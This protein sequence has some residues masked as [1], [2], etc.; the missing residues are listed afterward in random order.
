M[1]STDPYQNL[2]QY[3]WNRIIYSHVWNGKELT[4]GRPNNDDS[5]NASTRY[6]IVL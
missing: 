5:P 4:N 6:N 3:L 2:E 1:L